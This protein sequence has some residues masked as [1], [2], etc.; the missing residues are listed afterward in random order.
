M[1]VINMMLLLGLSAGTVGADVLV[2]ATVS[3]TS[4]KG[5]ATSVKGGADVVGIIVL[6]AVS[7]GM[8]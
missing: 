8:G 6:L 7:D 2:I 1:A 3:F 5:G 4:V